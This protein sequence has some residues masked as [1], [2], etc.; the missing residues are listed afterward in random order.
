MMSQT[1]LSLGK[2]PVICLFRK[3]FEGYDLVACNYGITAFL[4]HLGGGPFF[5]HDINFLQGTAMFWHVWTPPDA[6][7]QIKSVL[8]LLTRNGRKSFISMS[9]HDGQRSFSPKLCPP[10]KIALFA[11]NASFYKTVFCTLFVVFVFSIGRKR[12][13]RGCG[14]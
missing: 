5:R 12:F 14:K 4:R 3:M 2:C 10:H 8:Q 13:T 11:D 9:V 7:G 1:F 6:M